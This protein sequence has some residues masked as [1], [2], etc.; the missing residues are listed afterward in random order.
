MSLIWGP[1]PAQTLPNPF[2][3]GLLSPLMI[4]L[5]HVGYS[6]SERLLLLSVF[7]PGL[8]PNIFICNPV[9][10]A[11]LWPMKGA[12]AGGAAETAGSAQ[13]CS[14]QQRPTQA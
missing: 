4:V 5:I 14:A 13:F 3:Y 10:V 12:R 9:L 2:G 6:D 8:T 1:F 7:F 11:W